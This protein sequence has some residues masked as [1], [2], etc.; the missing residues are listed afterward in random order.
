MASSIDFIYKRVQVLANKD[1]ASG[2]IPPAVFNAELKQAQID[3]IVEQRKRFETGSLSYDNLAPLKTSK[4]LSVN[5]SGIATKPSD[6]LFYDNSTIIFFY[7][8]SKGASKQSLRSVDL[9]PRYEVGNRISSLVNPPTRYFPI[10]TEAGDTLQF[11]PEGLGSVE[12]YYLKEPADPFWGYDIVNDEAV[13]NLGLSTEVTLP[14]ELLPNL[15][16]RVCSQVG[17][18]VRQADLTSIME[19]KMDKNEI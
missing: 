16:R 2:Y 4:S 12:L 9:I 11:Y 17:V 14:F 5:T 18:S 15:I 13:F 6:Y 1:Q 8:D 7:K 19:Q 10:V 3:E